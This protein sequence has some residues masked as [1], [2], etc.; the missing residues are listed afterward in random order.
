DEMIPTSDGNYLIGGYSY[1][2]ISGNKTNTNY[3]L[4]DYWVVKIAPDGNILWQQTYGGSDYDELYTLLATSDRGFLLG[5]TSRSPVSG[6]KTNAHFGNYDSWA[7][8]LSPE[9]T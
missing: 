2:L 7:I 8:K 3:G 6:N 9:T 1:S 5:G 4:E